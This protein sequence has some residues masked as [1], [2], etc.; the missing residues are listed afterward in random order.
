MKREKKRETGR[1]KRDTYKSVAAG[2]K[3]GGRGANTKTIEETKRG[4][5]EEEE[6]DREREQRTD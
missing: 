4:V 2:R 3:G 1:K 6:R 5:G